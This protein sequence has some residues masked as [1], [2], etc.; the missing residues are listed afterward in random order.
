MQDNPRGVV[1]VVDDEWLIRMELADALSGAGW[2][3]IELASGEAALDLLPANH[4]VRIL[5]TDIRLG[6]GIDG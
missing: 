2:T 3:V 5:V 6:H 4:P 1:V